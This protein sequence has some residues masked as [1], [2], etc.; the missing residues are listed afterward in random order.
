MCELIYVTLDMFQT[1]GNTAIS[2]SCFYLE[3][4]I[5]A[6]NLGPWK[7]PLVMAQSRSKLVMVSVREKVMQ[8]R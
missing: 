3:T 5:G 7:G 2:S 4:G 6:L 8:I 1:A